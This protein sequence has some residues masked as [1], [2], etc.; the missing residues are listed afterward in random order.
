SHRWI[1][2]RRSHPT[3]WES[4]RA[5][6]PDRP[7]SPTDAPARERRYPDA[8]GSS[9]ASIS[10]ERLR[11]AT[12]RS[13]PAARRRGAA[14][15]RWPLQPHALAHGCS[16]G[17]RSAAQAHHP[18]VHEVRFPRVAGVVVYGGEVAA[19]VVGDEVR[20]HLAPA[21]LGEVVARDEPDGVDHH[22]AVAALDGRD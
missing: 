3:S 21:V 7:R 20:R 11:A 8:R 10:T 15:V 4:V 13:D 2:C 19:Y 12:I 18:G 17:Q 9:Q 5:P 1:V 6:G 14:I 16:L 22:G